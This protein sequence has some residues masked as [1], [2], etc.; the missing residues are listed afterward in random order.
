MK[1]SSID[2]I[3]KG[4]RESHKR[5][6]LSIGFIEMTNP[7][8]FEINPRNCFLAFS[9]DHDCLAVIG[10]SEDI[11]NFEADIGITVN[12]GRK[13]YGCYD[14]V[15]IN[16]I[17]FYREFKENIIYERHLIDLFNNHYKKEITQQ[18]KEK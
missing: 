4:I 7:S 3:R 1:D 16:G 6:L 12:S 18:Q 2:N 17:R 13:G 14:G 11:N 15:E 10:S 5:Y 8:L 9:V